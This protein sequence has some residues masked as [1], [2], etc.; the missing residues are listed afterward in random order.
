MEYCSL[1][2]L[3]LLSSS[4]TSTTECHFHFGPA[5]S[6]FLELF[7]CS[8]P[9]V[10]WTLTDLGGAHLSVSYLFAFSYCSWDSRGKNT[11]VVCHS[12]LQ[13]TTFCQNM[14]R[15]YCNQINTILGHVEINRGWKR[16]DSR[17]SPPQV[18]AFSMKIPGISSFKG[19]QL[20]V[21]PDNLVTR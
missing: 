21:S 5:S 10:Y 8:S 19:N 6:F 2:Y 1:Q 12:L 14:L 13:W 3:T 20:Q 18:Y 9:V 4:D 16:T 7:L 15:S 11:E 17:N